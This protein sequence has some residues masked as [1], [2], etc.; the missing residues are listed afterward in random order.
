MKI[1]SLTYNELV[2]QFKKPSIKIMFALILISAIVLPMVINK[3]PVD[4]YSEHALESNKFMLEQ[5]KQDVEL[6]KEDKTQKGQ[7]KYQYAL[8]ERDS[9]QMNVD[10]EIGFD[11]W[12]NGLVEYYRLAAY[13]LAAI[14]FVLEGYE[15][16]TVMENLIGVDPKKVESYYSDKTTLAKKKEVEAFY[17]AE[18]ERYKKILET[19]DYQ[20]YTEARIEKEKE[21]IAD[22][23]SEIDAY[24][25]LKEK[26]LKLK[27]V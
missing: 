26:I 12:R 18:K 16:S 2:K 8:I 4:K 24:E 17:T 13:N 10:Y 11:D 9:S 7:I 22:S 23:Q 25:K 27:K 21:R 6:F 5:Q 3:I 19:D 1:L 20:G 15:Q 14:E